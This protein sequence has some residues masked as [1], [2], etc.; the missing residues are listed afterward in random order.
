MRECC[1]LFFAYSFFSQ[2]AALRRANIAELPEKIRTNQLAKAS[3]KV[4]LF[5]RACG[6]EGKFSL[7]H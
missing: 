7:A 4:N 2:L 1:A 5:L 3:S 6:E